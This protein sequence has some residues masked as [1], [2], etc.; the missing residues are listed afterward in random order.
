MELSK[1]KI[2]LLKLWKKFTKSRLYSTTGRGVQTVTCCLKH[3]V[4]NFDKQGVPKIMGASWWRF[5]NILTSFGT[6]FDWKR[7]KFDCI[8]P[9]LSCSLPYL[10]CIMVCLTFVS[11]WFLEYIFM[12]STFSSVFCQIPTTFFQNLTEF[13][14]HSSIF[15]LNFASFCL[16]STTF[17]LFWQHF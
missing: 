1:R 6:S 10:N 15:Q 3:T 5:M 2:L 11:G 9:F 4:G 14:P 8:F 12:V 7:K 13:L 16:H 17:N